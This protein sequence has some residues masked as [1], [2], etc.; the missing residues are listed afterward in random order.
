MKTIGDAI[1]RHRYLWFEG[2]VQEIIDFD[3]V[4]NVIQ[5]K[6]GLGFVTISFR[7]YVENCVLAGLGFLVNLDFSFDEYIF[8]CL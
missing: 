2:F 7:S 8:F 6:I 1:S 4:D 3:A 5:V